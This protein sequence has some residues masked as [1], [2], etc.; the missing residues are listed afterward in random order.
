M[1]LACGVTRIVRVLEA[2]CYCPR[3]WLCRLPTGATLTLDET[4]LGD[5]IVEPDT[6]T[7]KT[8]GEHHRTRCDD[9]V[10]TEASEGSFPASDPPSWTSSTALASRDDVS[11][12]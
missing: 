8:G 7:G 2:S 4:E 12:A 3:Q 1:A 5:L 6:D 10:V 11:I 9:D